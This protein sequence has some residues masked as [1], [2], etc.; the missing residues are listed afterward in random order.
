MDKKQKLDRIIQRKTISNITE[1]NLN[2]VNR[3][4]SNAMNNMDEETPE[5][6]Y[7]NE[8]YGKINLNCYRINIIF[9]LFFRFKFKYKI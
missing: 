7:I 9:N 4:K 3:S 5:D 6:K 1:G 2:N 8:K